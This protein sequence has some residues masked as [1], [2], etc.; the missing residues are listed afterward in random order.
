MNI[1]DIMIEEVKST[2][3]KQEIKL[4]MGKKSKEALLT[5]GYSDE[6]GARS[7]RRVMDK[8]LLDKIAVVLLDTFPKP[9]NISALAD[10]GHLRIKVQ[11]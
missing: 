7:L 9:K 1:I 10:K 11:G 5:L 2:L 4:R 8:E 6:Y 3:Q